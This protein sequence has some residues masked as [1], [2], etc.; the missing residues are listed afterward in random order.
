MYQNGA[1]F[2]RALEFVEGPSL[3]DFMG[4]HPTIIPCYPITQ[5][6]AEKFHAITRHYSSGE[7]SRV[8]DFVD[9]LLLAELG[10][11]DPNRLSLA[12]KATFEHRNTHSLPDEILDPPRE[13]T[14]PYQNL[15]AQVSVSYRTLDEANI[16]M[17]AFL[18]PLLKGDAISI[19]KPDYWAWD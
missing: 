19:W 2:R 7:S 5:Q 17:K 13:W 8:K 1:D 10:N 18:N 16:A 12:I 3:L 4:I 14:K 15:A 6:I 11:I 9:I